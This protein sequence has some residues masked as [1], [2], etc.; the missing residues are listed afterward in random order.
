MRACRIVQWTGDTTDDTCLRG[1]QERRSADGRP[2][3]VRMP[4]LVMVRQAVSRSPSRPGVAAR[5]QTRLLRCSAVQ[6][7]ACPVALS[8]L[9][10]SCTSK[11]SPLHFGPLGGPFTPCVPRRTRSAHPALPRQRPLRVRASAIPDGRLV[12]PV[13]GCAPS[14]SAEALRPAA[15][16]LAAPVGRDSHGYYG[17]SA[18]VPALGISRPTLIGSQPEVPALLVSQVLCGF[19]YPFDP[20][21][22]RTTLGTSQFGCKAIVAP[23]LSDH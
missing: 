14:L 15:A 1:S 23:A 3:G 16:L 8:G 5:H 7:C 11:S 21:T 18:P 17:L 9:G 12:R 22:W 4:P 19:R 20:L 6:T 2:T 10:E 13:L